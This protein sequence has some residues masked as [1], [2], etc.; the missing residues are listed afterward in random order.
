MARTTTHR[1]PCPACKRRRQRLRAKS[2][3]LNTLCLPIPR[4]GFTLATIGALYASL[5]PAALF[6]GALAVIAWRHN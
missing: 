4:W 3:L 5:T 2:P 6:A 1:A